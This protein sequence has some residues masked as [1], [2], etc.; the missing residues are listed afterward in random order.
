M[1]G[2]GC[3]EVEAVEWQAAHAAT[4]P[5][6]CPETGTNPLRRPSLIFT[7]P[8]V[9]TGAPLVAEEWWWILRM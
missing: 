3:G 8:A 1:F 6:Y 5:T 4:L 7:I 2:A 9:K